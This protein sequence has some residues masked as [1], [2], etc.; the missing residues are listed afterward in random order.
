[1][2]IFPF[3]F[4]PFRFSQYR[5]SCGNFISLVLLSFHLKW[6]WYRHPKMNDLTHKIGVLIFKIQSIESG[7]IDRWTRWC[8]L[9]DHCLAQLGQSLESAAIA[10]AKPLLV[11]EG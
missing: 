6:L 8:G 5:S 2:I 1:M 7:T 4:F 3:S 11:G 10:A 9:L